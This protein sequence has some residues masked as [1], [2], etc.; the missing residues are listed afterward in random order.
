MTFTTSRR[1]FLALSG[2]AGAGL[3]APVW[4]KSRG[5]SA[6]SP[7]LQAVLDRWVADKHVP[8]AVAS[9]ARGLEQAVFMVA[10][11][12]SLDDGPTV[13]AASLVRA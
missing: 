7:A 8:G 3:A 9:M 5:V 11:T 10:G 2:L 6:P 1:S 12:E 4:G 13:R